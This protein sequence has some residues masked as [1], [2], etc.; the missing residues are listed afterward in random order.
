LYQGVK[1]AVISF[2]LPPGGPLVLV[3]FGVLTWRWWPRL[4]R[5]C[6]AAGAA[7]L[8][9]AA[10]PVVSNALVASLGGAQPLDMAALKNA[11][12]IAIL[13][14]GVRPSALEYGGD[15]LGRLTLERVRYGALLAR[16]S[17]LP[18][19]VTGGT[20]N[21]GIRAEGELMREALS[22]EYGVAVRWVDNRARTTRENARNAAALLLAEN[23]RRVILV[24]H[25]FDVRR[26][27]RWFEEAGLQVLVAPTQ[28]AHL[29][30]PKA[31]DFLPSVTALSTS[32]F[33]CYEILALVR[34][35]IFGG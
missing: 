17:E 16:Q 11:D 3:A 18:V 33:A 26:A 4:A 15:T 29:T 30:L 7:A 27:R 20:V 1:L 21:D 31:E 5:G 23:K 9:L 35:H 2:V 25:G 24:M 32:Y 13:G 34:D 14:G 12:A 19:L 6:C 8:W 22:T 28:V 10:M